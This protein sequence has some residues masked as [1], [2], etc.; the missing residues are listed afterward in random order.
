LHEDRDFHTIQTVEAAYRQYDYLRGN[1][2]WDT[3]LGSC[4]TVPGRSFAHGSGARANVPNCLSASP[5]ESICMRSRRWGSSSWRLVV[6]LAPVRTL[7]RKL[8]HGLT[9]HYFSL[10]QAVPTGKEDA[11]GR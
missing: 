9:T 11:Q 3:R 2:S 1:G 8:F 4:G 5:R 10:V 6:A 7:C